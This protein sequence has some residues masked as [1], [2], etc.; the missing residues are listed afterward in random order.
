MQGEDVFTALAVAQG[1]YK[2]VA[3]AV[4]SKEPGNLRAAADEE[5]RQISEAFPTDRVDLAI[6]GTRVGGLSLQR[7]KPHA[8]VTD[9]AAFD[10]WLVGRGWAQEREVMDLSLL[11]GDERLVMERV[12]RE[13]LPQA[14]RTQ[15]VPCVKDPLKLLSHVG[16]AVLDPETGEAVPGVAWDAGGQVSGTRISGCDPADVMSAL[17]ASRTS[18]DEA[19]RPLL[20]GQVA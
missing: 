17:A 13:E 5:L 12:M 8:V 1:A 11:T 9:Q 6:G 18:L 4:S 2:L 15:A 14:F 16:E 19:V 10:G 3:Q 20:G 7:T